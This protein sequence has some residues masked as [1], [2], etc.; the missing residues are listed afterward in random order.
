MGRL[1]VKL[2]LTYNFNFLRNCVLLEADLHN[3]NI[4]P[5]EVDPGMRDKVGAGGFLP[6]GFTGVVAGAATCFFG[7][8]GFD[9]IA[10]AS[11]HFLCL[12]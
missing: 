10:T 9:T 3:W 4:K 8:Q 2:I 6:F 5:E 7:F 12:T 1:K 11:T